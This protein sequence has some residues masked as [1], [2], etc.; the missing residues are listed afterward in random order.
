ME[1]YLLFLL[2]SCFNFA[3]YGQNDKRTFRLDL[4]LNMESDTVSLQVNEQTIFCDSI[5]SFN[6]GQSDPYLPPMIHFIKSKNSVFTAT[7]FDKNVKI[8]HGRLNIVLVINSETFRFSTK[9]K[10]GSYIRL[11]SK[12]AWDQQNYLY[13]YF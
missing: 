2:C 11:N 7:S 5:I 9:L 12:G 8:K 13:L 3:S 10:N 4:Y 6:T 1:K